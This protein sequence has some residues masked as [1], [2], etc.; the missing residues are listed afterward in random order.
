MI[1]DCHIL[2][3]YTTHDATFSEIILRFQELFFTSY[4][5]SWNKQT[6]A[7]GYWSPATFTR[8]LCLES[9]ES[10]PTCT[11][12]GCVLWVRVRTLKMW[13]TTFQPYEKSLQHQMRT[14]KIVKGKMY[15][16]LLPNLVAMFRLQQ[17]RSHAKGNWKSWLEF[18]VKSVR[19]IV[20]F[21]F[22][23]CT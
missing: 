22:F 21:N 16:F 7:H 4:F 20:S 3:S 11:V 19:K 9:R 6:R 17:T 10:A 2:Q 1:W 18:H 23:R 8:A 5:F 12:G 15:I 13:L 14:T